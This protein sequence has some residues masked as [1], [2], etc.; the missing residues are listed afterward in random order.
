MNDPSS[1][2]E[3]RDTIA[4]LEQAGHRALLDALAD[5]AVYARH[6]D[7]RLVTAALARRLGVGPKKAKLMLAAARAAVA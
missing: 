6:G 1:I 7:G 3:H 5:P 2:V 4:H